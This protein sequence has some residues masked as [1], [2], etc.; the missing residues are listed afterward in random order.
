[1]SDEIDLAIIKELNRDS[2]IKVSHLAQLVHLTAPA[3]AARIQRLEDTG[4]ITNYTIE[5]DL[6]KVG[7][8]R[9]VFIQVAVQAQKQSAYLAFI[10]TH[11]NDFR[12]HYRTTGEFDYL[13]E[14]AFP[15]RHVL[16][17]FLVH[18]N[19]FATYQVIDVIDD[20]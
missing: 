4:V 12:H 2:R 7:L 17:D 11:H 1:M 6:D 15:D 20:I 14:G 3:V 16:N 18:L 8:P 5:V 13:L 10:K 9:Q 19:Q